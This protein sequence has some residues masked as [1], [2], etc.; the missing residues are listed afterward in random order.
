[1]AHQQYVDKA[2]L[3]T[4]LGLSGSGQDTN[5]DNAI[6]GASRQIDGFCG[7]YFYQDESVNARYYTP[8]NYVEVAV[9]DISTTTGLV[10]SL[11]TTDNGTYDTTITLNTDFILKPMNPEHIEIS[12]ADYRF[13][14]N[15]IKIIPTRSS[16]RFDPLIINNIKVEAKWGFSKVPPA[17][18][19]ATLIQ[20]T[21]LFKRKDTPFNVF[22]N[23]QTGTQ[24]LFSKF[25][26]DA[27][28]LIR[29]YKK[30]VL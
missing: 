29:P 18:K 1:M 17:I 4:Y 12:D 9:D 11:D 21:R 14:Q 8:T 10:V 28:E 7:R 2:D 25:D 6:D 20:A 15:F 23:E 26:P 5:L 30:N 22:G 16:E 24:E 27:K 3:K 13:P 19:Q